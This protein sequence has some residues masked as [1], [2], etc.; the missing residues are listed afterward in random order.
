MH[1]DEMNSG[2]AAVLLRG[3]LERPGALRLEGAAAQQLRL[4]RSAPLVTYYPPAARAKG[5]DG[6][7]IVD[8]LINSAGQVLEAQVVSESPENEG[9]GIAALDAAKT[10]EF[11]NR[12]QREVLMSIVIEFLP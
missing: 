8:L 5:L 4:L 12:T 2:V 7:V 6:T 9:F 1:P 10:Y 3:R 11:D